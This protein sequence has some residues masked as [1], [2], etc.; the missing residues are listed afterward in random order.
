MATVAGRTVEWSTPT[1][2]ADVDEVEFG[3]RSA[4]GLG[5]MVRHAFTTGW[6]VRIV[7][8]N[9]GDAELELP[10]CVLTWEPRLDHPAWLLAAGVAGA[11]AIQPPDGI[12]P[13]L[14]GR[15]TMGTCA[16]AGP[17]GLGFGPL[18]LGPGSRYVVA[19]QWDWYRTARAFDQGCGRRACRVGS[20]SRST[21]R[22]S[23]RP[24]PTRLWSPKVCTSSRCGAS[25]SSAPRWPGGSRL[26]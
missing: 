12:G 14:G 20:I 26:R 18:S 16:A 1:V 4:V 7:L 21:R 9:L 10:S 11:M 25:S 5:L 6:G 17:D 19:W 24:I 3:Y 8:S 22:C 23:S 15:L 13:L 2:A